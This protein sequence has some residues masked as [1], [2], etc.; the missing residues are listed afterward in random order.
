MKAVVLIVG[1]LTGAMFFTSLIVTTRLT[2]TLNPAETVKLIGEPYEESSDF[3]NTVESYMLQVL[4]QFQLKTLFES[5]GAYNP[6]KVIDVMSYFGASGADA[7]NHSGLVYRLSDLIEWSKAYSVESGG[8][9]DKN[10]VI[11]CKQP[12][13]KYYYYYTEEFLNQLETGELQLVLEDDRMDVESF[14]ND[15]SN[16]TLTSSGVSDKI[17]IYDA[18][19][20]K[21]YTDCWNY[22]D[23]VRENYAPLGAA[24]LLQ[25]V[26]ER[27]EL[28]GKLMVIYDHLASV[29]TSINDKYSRYKS[30]W[31]HL[32]EGNTNFTYLYIDQDTKKVTTNKSE[33]ANLM[34]KGESGIKTNIEECIA[35]MKSGKNVKYIFVYPKL[36]DFETNMDILPTNEWDMVRSYDTDKTYD[37]IFAVAVDTSYPVKDMFYERDRIY[38]KN[39]PLLRGGFVILCLSGI[40]FLISFVMSGLMAGRKDGDNE[41]H[42]TGFD[43]WKTEIAAVLQN[44]DAQLGSR[45]GSYRRHGNDRQR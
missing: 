2:G 21:L 7:E 3:S 23:S 24:N 15:L 29:L 22:G 14:L 13:G 10:A 27:P 9:Y 26:N 30:G 19:G 12:S 16:G 20:S 6:D 43:R 40:L 5:D 33:Y 1:V 38:E 41:V 44:L 39:I 32:E 42:L 18:E 28:N 4:E 25:V 37:S 8:V 31:E 35:D 45:N 11:V 34:A 36:K 17:S